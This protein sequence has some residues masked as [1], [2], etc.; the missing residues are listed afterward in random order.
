MVADPTGMDWYE[1]QDENGNTHAMWLKNCQDKQFTD[2][3]GNLWN[4]V[5]TSYSFGNYAFEQYQNKDGEFCLRG[6]N[7]GNT[8]M[9][10]LDYALQQLEA[11]VTEIPGTSHNSSILA[12]HSTTGLNA[13][14]DET[15]WCSSFVNWCFT[16]AGIIGTNSAA[17]K[18]WANWGQDLGDTPARGSVGLVGTADKI[19]HVGFTMGYKPNGSIELLGG[20]QGTPGSVTV[21][22]YKSTAFTGFRYPTGYTPTYLKK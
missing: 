9:P 10:W 18:S 6:V 2:D 4:N 21:S 8:E 13:K 16:E 11:G 5:G 15:P 19:T 3:N 1:A 17:A 22:I 12:Y 14:T 20:N 7:T